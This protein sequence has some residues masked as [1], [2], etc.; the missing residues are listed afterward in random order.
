MYTYIV[1]IQ[2]TKRTQPLSQMFLKICHISQMSAFVM[3]GD[4]QNIK[5]DDPIV[6]YEC[7]WEN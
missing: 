3:Y 6:L 2:V 5:S 4:D 7:E 1:A